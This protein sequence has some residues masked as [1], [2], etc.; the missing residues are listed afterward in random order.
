VGDA[1]LAQLPD[2]RVDLV[3]VNDA[4]GSTACLLSIPCAVSAAST[5]VWIV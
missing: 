2:Q 5:P 1:G 3:G 4:L